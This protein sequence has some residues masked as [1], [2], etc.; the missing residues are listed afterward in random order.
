MTK[1]PIKA[2]KDLAKKYN[3]TQLIL[4]AWDGDCQTIVTYGESLEQC[5]QAATLGNDIKTAL[6]WP[7]SLHK[8]PSRVKRLLKQIQTLKQEV[9]MLKESTLQSTYG[10][11]GFGLM[12][13]KGSSNDGSRTEDI[14]NRDQ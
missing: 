1:I 13:N 8:T 10:A 4:W 7:K 11:N 3:K 14:Y 12:V 6:G 5:A 2:A 9:K